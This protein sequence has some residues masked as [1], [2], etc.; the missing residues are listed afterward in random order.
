MNEKKFCFISCINDEQYYK[1]CL[2]Y[3]NKLNVPDE[4]EIEIKSITNSKSI[5]SGYN[6][7]MNSSDAKY[8]IY[9]HQDI[10]IINENFLYDILYIFENNTD[11]GMIGVVGSKTVPVNAIWWE[12]SKKFGKVYDSS[13]GALSELKFNDVKRRYEEVKI[14]DGVIMVTQYDLPWREDIFDG[15]HFYDASQSIEFIKNGYK[16]VIPNQDKPWIIHD[17]GMAN[18]KE[19]E[20][21]RQIFIDEYYKD[22]FPLVSILIPTHN[23]INYFTL[24]LESVLNQTYKNIEIIIGDNSD[25]DDTMKLV[26]DYI[27]KHNNIKYIKNTTNLGLTGNGRKLFDFASGEYVNYLMDDDLYKKNKIEEMMKYFIDDIDKGLSLV[28]SSRTIIDEA[29]KEYGTYLNIENV[30]GK[31]TYFKGKDLIEYVL[32]NKLNIIGEPTTVL[33]RKESLKES[34]SEYKGITFIPIVDVPMWIDLLENGDALFISKPLSCFR[35]HSNQ[36]QN[37]NEIIKLGE[38]EWIQMRE[39]SGISF[40]GDN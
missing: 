31:D 20:N 26:N 27:N 24:A 34:F 1:E 17:C 5:A 8:K 25:N 3:I 7:A 29:G 39:L 19:Y 28:T 4:Y 21:Y 36:M 13:R 12:S 33:F 32:K 18:M 40:G 35:V 2:H 38:K 9:L 37:E 14:I 16:V 6:E 30:I 15:Y 23:R 10:F 11:I 22:V